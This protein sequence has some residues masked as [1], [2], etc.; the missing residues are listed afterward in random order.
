MKQNSKTGQRIEKSVNPFNSKAKTFDIFKDMIEKSLLISNNV[1]ISY[2]TDDTS[3]MKQNDLEKILKYLNENVNENIELITHKKN[4]KRFKA[5]S[6]AEM[7]K[8]QQK[9]N[10][11]LHKKDITEEDK[12]EISKIE[13]ELDKDR[14]YI[15]NIENEI[16]LL[17]EKDVK[18]VEETVELSKLE[19]IIQDNKNDLKIFEIIW[20]FQLKGDK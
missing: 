9:K 15:K 14:N 7:K 12:N 8:L 1:Y 16:K 17:S 19:Q 13:L 5:S 2:S 18:T 4:Y 3:L 20:H 6:N 11:L 10:L